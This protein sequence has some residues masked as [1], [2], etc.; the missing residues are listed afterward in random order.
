VFSVTVFLILSSI[1]D[2][3]EEEEDEAAEEEEEEVM[4]RTEHDCFRHLLNGD[5]TDI[6]E[7]E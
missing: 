3:K 2:P 7:N 1:L 6:R 4:A 5:P